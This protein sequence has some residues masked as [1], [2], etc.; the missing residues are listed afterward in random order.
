MAVF[1]TTTRF[2]RPFEA[3]ALEHGILAVHREN[4]GI[5]SNCASLESLINVNGGGRG[6]KLTVLDGKTLTERNTVVENLKAT[7]QKLPISGRPCC[8]SLQLMGASTPSTC[9]ESPRAV[10]SRIGH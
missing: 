6:I 8:L 10:R 3:W 9:A 2:S 7:C 4:L 1:V 5:W